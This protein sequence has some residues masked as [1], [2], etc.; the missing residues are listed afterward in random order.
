MDM[1]RKQTEAR[2][3]ALRAERDATEAAFA[4]ARASAMQALIDGRPAPKTAAMAERVEL[5][6]GA[7][8]DLTERLAGIDDREARG[9]R[10]KQIERAQAS[11][12]DRRALAAAVDAA[13]AELSRAW[14][15]YRE[16]VRRTVGAAAQAGADTV[17]LARVSLN[18]GPS[19]ALVKALIAATSGLD[20]VRALAVDT[21]NKPQHAVALAAAEDRVLRSLD[22][23][24]LRVRATSPQRH[25]ARDAAEQ[26]KHMEQENQI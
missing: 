16:A 26:L 9:A 3:A 25:V 18:G 22:A 23:E 15:A 20:M 5:L 7:I 1:D 8:A 13:P 17:P 12:L 6:D 11:G 14:A 19:D 21:A 24:M 4:G 2:I 10:V